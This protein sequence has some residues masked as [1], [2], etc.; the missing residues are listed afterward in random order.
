MFT[1]KATLFSQQIRTFFKKYNVGKCDNLI[2]KVGKVSS[3][4]QT[5]PEH[6]AKPPYY[7]TCEKPN[8]DDFIEI[9]NETQIRGMR[10]ACKLAANILKKCGNMIQVRFLQYL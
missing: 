4:R 1:M 6:I 5:V 9:K 8:A 10:D 7:E 2:R 3:T